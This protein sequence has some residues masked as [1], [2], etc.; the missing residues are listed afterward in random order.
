MRKLAEMER[1]MDTG[2]ES[3]VECSDSIGCE[4]EDT[5]VV[6]NVTET[7]YDKGSESYY[8]GVMNVVTHKTATIAFLSR[9]CIDLCS[10]K[11]SA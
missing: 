10:R 1:D 9:S 7:K 6:L 5:A 2:E 4:E 3:F 11:T 8:D